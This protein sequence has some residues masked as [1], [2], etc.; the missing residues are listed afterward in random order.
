[1]KAMNGLVPAE[2]VGEREQD[3]EEWKVNKPF[4][5]WIENT[6]EKRYDR[7]KDDREI[8]RVSVTIGRF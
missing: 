7:S 6:I 8:V 1:M 4:K 3:E 5:N 2:E